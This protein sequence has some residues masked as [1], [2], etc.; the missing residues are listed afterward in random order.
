MTGILISCFALTIR[1]GEARYEPIVLIVKDGKL[2]PF[3]DN[4]I[5]QE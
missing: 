5:P 3:N 4:G 1:T 2:E